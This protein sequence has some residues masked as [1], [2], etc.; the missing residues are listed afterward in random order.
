MMPTKPAVPAEMDATDATR[1]VAVRD[2]RTGR[3]RVLPT[4]HVM[5]G[6]LAESIS[7]DV[8]LAFLAALGRGRCS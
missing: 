5:S 7:D 8:D 3:L 4:V 1:L 2:R 6:G